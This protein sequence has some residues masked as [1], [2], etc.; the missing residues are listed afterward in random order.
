M[1]FYELIYLK[2]EFNTKLKEGSIRQIIT[3]FKN[4]IEIYIDKGRESFRLVFSCSPG[5]TA[6]FL[7]GYREG[8]KSNRLLFFESIYGVPIKEISLTKND[9]ILTFE[10]EHEQKII[11]K[12]FSNKANAILSKEDIIIDVFKD[13]DEIGKLIPEG[14][15]VVFPKVIEDDG[16]TKEKIIKAN[17]LLSRT[18]IPNLIR[19]NSL[20]TKS[21]KELIKYIEVV[22]H[23]LKNK[24]SFRKLENGSTTLISEQYLGTKTLEEFDSVNDLVAFRFK[25]YS[26][27]QRL[28]Q[29]KNVYLKAIKIQL[30]RL[31]SSLLNLEKADKGIEKAEKFGKFGHLLMANAHQKISNAKEITVPDLYEQ[32]K[33]IL[34]PLEKER[35]IVENAELYYQKA[36]NAVKSYEEALKRI[37]KLNDRSERLKKMQSSLQEIN[38]LW[39][40]D[41]WKKRFKKEIEHL[42]IETSKKKDSVLPFHQLDIEDYKIWIGKNAKNNDKLIQMSHKEDIWMH[43][44][45]VPGSHLVIRMANNKGE[46]PKKVI[47]K[48]ASYAAFNSKAKGS[49]L[50]PVIF[51]KRKFV[52][53]PKG[54]APGAVLVQ[55]EGV[56]LVTPIKP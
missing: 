55:K 42:G 20:E 15:K 35:S 40:I 18:E 27:L 50:V 16:S 34:I 38:R 26:H 17:P 43:A 6:L 21:T 9:R 10:F 51:T 31:R 32:G 56:V 37:P 48:A 25:N 2:N 3:P 54:A 45:G 44:R 14:K 47:E 11:F 33:Q 8:K 22:T 28:R 4:L 13:Y 53:K 1:N 23:Q 30:K 5:N 52:R 24:P 19:A 29:Q 39:E 49:N 36:S 12:L 41:D 7:D 46:P